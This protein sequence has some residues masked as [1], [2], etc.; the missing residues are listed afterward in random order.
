MVF[1]LIKK[2]FTKNRSTFC[3]NSYADNEIKEGGWFKEPVSG[4]LWILGIGFLGFMLWASLIPLD[5]G[6]VATGTLVVDKKRNSIQHYSGGVVDAINYK[7]GA[8]VNKGDV[9]VKILDVNQSNNLQILIDQDKQ[10]NRQIN[11]LREL[12]QE[13]FYPKLQFEEL[14]RQSQEVRNKINITKDELSRTEIKSPVSG[15]LMA[16]SVTVGG[17]VSPGQRIFDVAPTED[18]LEVES[19]IQPFLIDKIKPGLGVDVRFSAL[20]QRTTPLISGNVNWVSS[21]TY[22]AAN[23]ASYYLARVAIDKSKIQNVDLDSLVAGMP[24]DVI[25]K[26]GSRTFLNYLIKPFSDRAALSLKER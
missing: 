22:Q 18:T 11:A 9:V 3:D 23:G 25:I 24:A 16:L 19:I 1:K 14:R 17:V 4:G 2:I 12:V 13:G 5:E 26:T 15:K 21:D 8:K 6:V 20:N 10:L 7:E